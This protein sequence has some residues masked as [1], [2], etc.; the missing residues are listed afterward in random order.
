MLLQGGVVVNPGC[1]RPGRRR[2]PPAHGSYDQVMDLAN[3]RQRLED[4]RARRLA[5]AERL[6]G[7]EAQPVESGELSK[8]DQHPAELGT[9]TFERELELTTL[10]IV[11]GELRDIDDALRRLADGTYG[12]CEECGKPIDEARLEAVPW[13]RY[14]VVDQARVERALS[15]P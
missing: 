4:E 2:R 8:I 7:E 14:C 9:E 15:R 13:A 3:V 1:R 5:L 6:R 10:T 11:E 12:I